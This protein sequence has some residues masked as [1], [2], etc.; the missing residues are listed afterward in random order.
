LIDP[1][2]AINLSTNYYGW[3]TKRLL[4][5]ADKHAGGR[6]ISVLEGGYDLH[7]LAHSVGV[8]LETLLMIESNDVDASR[9]L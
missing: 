1:L 4:E 8:H 7:A 3:M 9:V 2:G 6:L 5:M